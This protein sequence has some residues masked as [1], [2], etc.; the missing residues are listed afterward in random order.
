MID[1]MFTDYQSFFEHFIKMSEYA[2]ILG[3]RHMYYGGKQTKSISLKQPNETVYSARKEAHLQFVAM[4][5][6]LA[7]ILKQN[8]VTVF[9]KPSP[10]L[11]QDQLVL[12]IGSD[13]VQP[14]KSRCGIITEYPHYDLI[15]FDG[16]NNIRTLLSFL[17]I[18]DSHV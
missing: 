15:E 4:F 12:D 8:D 16:Q 11:D 7:D 1:N 9:L 14:G 5:K 10:N 13:H 18:L 17:L 2:H 3:A 6:K